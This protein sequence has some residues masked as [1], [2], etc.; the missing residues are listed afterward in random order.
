MVRN[1]NKITNLRSVGKRCSDKFVTLEV[2]QSFS[3][4]CDLIEIT[5]TFH[6]GMFAG[7][8]FHLWSS[9]PA[10]TDGFAE[11]LLQ[12]DFRFFYALTLANQKPGI[13]A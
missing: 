3:L 4:V 7:V 12:V 2:V 8:L 5:R 1:W 6:K 11:I 9:Q 13:G 10:G